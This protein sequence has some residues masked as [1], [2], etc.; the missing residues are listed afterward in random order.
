MFKNRSDIFYFSLMFFI[1]FPIYSSGQTIGSNYSQIGS[2]T[3]SHVQQTIGQPYAIFNSSVGEKIHLYQGQILPINKSISQT[4]KF[5]CAIYPN[6]VIEE[7]TISINPKSHISQIKIYDINGK[8]INHFQ[9]QSNK[10]SQKINIGSL[11]PGIYMLTVSEKNGNQG[12]F[13][14]N[15]I[16]NSK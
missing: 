2:F 7:T 1:G 13:K 8:L 14:I 11:S 9:F 10:N 5:E 15:K 3:N 16:S 6:P 12:S 4:E